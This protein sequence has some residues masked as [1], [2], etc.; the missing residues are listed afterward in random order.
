MEPV[1]C[2]LGSASQNSV[3]IVQPRYYKGMDR[4]RRVTVG[5][6][7]LLELSSAII[8]FSQTVDMFI[9]LRDSIE[10]TQ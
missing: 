4:C 10:N 2:R 9:A 3:T 5:R 6:V 1:S 8:S 7:G